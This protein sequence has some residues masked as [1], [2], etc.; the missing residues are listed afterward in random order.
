MA[1]NNKLD[2]NL[3][4]SSPPHIRTHETVSSAMYDVVI[5]LIPAFL[6]ATYFFGINAIILVSVCIVSAVLTELLMQ[7]L[8]GRR[9]TLFDGSAVVT[10][11]LLAF[12]LPPATP[13]WT[14]A[15][16]SFV[17]IGIAKELFGGL[18]KNVF[19]PA[20]FGRVFVSTLLPFPNAMTNYLKPFW[21]KGSS[22]LNFVL[23]KTELQVYKLV[24]NVGKEVVDA[25]STATPLKLMRTGGL[26]SSTTTF[27]ERLGFYSKLFLGNRSGNLG[28]TSVLAILIGAGYL[29]YKKHIDLKIPLS[30]LITTFLVILLFGKG[31][32]PVAHLFL[33]GIMLGSFFMATDWTTS[34]MTTQGK[35]IY[36]IGIGLFIGFIRLFGVKPEGVAIGILHM[37]VI[38][39]FIDRVF[40]PRKFGMARSLASVS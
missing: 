9:V 12:C 10:A 23:P 36:G 28:E 16:A 31:Q 3:I 11:V 32:D 34:P 13:W 30:I 5:A 19:N 4:V 39:L 33:G 29:L 1:F 18:G 7:R 6:A 14:A 2:Y 8:F 40:L 15:L 24:D 21:W 37:N 26:I 17:A 25:V 35:I 20:L 27:I 22:F 38:S